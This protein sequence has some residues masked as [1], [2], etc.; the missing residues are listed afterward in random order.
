MTAFNK[1]HVNFN[2]RNLTLIG[3]FLISLAMALSALA[4]ATVYEGFDY[5]PA[6]SD[7][8]GNN[9]GTGFSGSWVPGGYNAF[10]SD[11]Y[12]IAEGSLTFGSLLV[13]GNRVHASAVGDLAGLT[14]SLSQALGTAGTT[15]YISFLLRPEGALDAGQYNGF[16]GLIL[17]RP[18]A[19]PGP[20][21][22]P[23]ELFIGKPGADLIHEYVLENRGGTL[24][25][26]SGAPVEIGTT[27]LVVVRADFTAGIDKFTLYMNPTPG[28][29]EPG[30]GTVKEDIDNGIITELTI[31]STGEFSIDELRVGNTF[32]DVTPVPNWAG[33]FPPV[34]NPPAFN[35]AKAG[36]AIP[37]KF[38][39][40][41]DQ[42]LD[43]FAPGYPTSGEIP[44]DLSSPAVSV[45]ETVAAG[46]S[47][48]TYDPVADEYIY[49]WKTD[50]AWAGTCRTLVLNLADG[51]SHYAYFSFTR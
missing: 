45:D 5:S 33:F 22:E 31:Y 8:N 10:L 48:L 26:G 11:N 12:D 19:F 29:P 4:D 38:S 23:P 32:E 1:K 51:T 34:E 9:G 3:V 46:G 36:S 17:H 6:G 39:L 41:G 2:D 37:V 13:S 15:R 50:R 44:C 47:S 14:R 21:P 27:V 18:D 35:I 30:S 24:Q 42:G 43:I 7:L 20:I 28:G 25:V 40:G 49:V 16:F